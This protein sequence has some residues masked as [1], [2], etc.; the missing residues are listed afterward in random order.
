MSPVTRRQ[1]YLEAFKARCE[2]ILTSGG[3]NTNAGQ[4]VLLGELPVFGPGDPPVVIS[5]TPGD[6]AV[7]AQQGKMVATVLPIEL[8]VIAQ[9]DIDAPW[10]KVEEVVADIIKA[11]EQDDEQLWGGA[12][13]EIGAPSIRT[14]PREDGSTT[15]GVVVSYPVSYARAWGQG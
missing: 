10:V 11:I 6:D 1:F 5:I 4:A 12:K 9:P 8:Y 2:T 15:I 7:R 13:G 3:F 14:I